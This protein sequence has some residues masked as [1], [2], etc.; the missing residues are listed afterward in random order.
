MILE[1]PLAAVIITIIVT[2]TN[3][4]T[5]NALK[6][7]RHSLKHFILNKHE[8]GLDKANSGKCSELCEV[9]LLRPDQG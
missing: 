2:Q 4:T 9:A 5:D 3:E 6:T 8:K 7:D 1:G